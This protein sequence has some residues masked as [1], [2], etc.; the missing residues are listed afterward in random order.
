MPASFE[1]KFSSDKGWDINSDI[2]QRYSSSEIKVQR[3]EF[4]C[5]DPQ[6]MRQLFEPVLDGI[7]TH[8]SN[9]FARVEL[10]EV[11]FVF[12]VGGFADS[13]LLQDRIKKHFYKSFQI[14]VPQ[15]ASLAVFQGAV[16]FGQKPHVF[17]SRIMTSTYGIR[18]HRLFLDGLH[19]QSKKEIV[20]G[21]PS[22]KDVL[23]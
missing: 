22:C 10:S 15:N 13:L 21:I 17:D 18:L 20:N 23:F 16:M 6:I 3:N 9:L 7:I 4:L 19:P 2:E 12:L 8:L 5:L 1:S 11:K 14:I